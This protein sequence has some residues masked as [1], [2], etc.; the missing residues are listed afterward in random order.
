MRIGTV[1]AP[2]RVPHVVFDM[3]GGGRAGCG[4]PT[5]LRK[6]SLKSS[7]GC[8]VRN[9]VTTVQNSWSCSRA[10]QGVPRRQPGP[11]SAAAHLRIKQRVSRL[12]CDLA[13]LRASAQTQANTNLIVASV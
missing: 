1:V 6:L 9:R 11:A 12:H 5:V 4:G 10:V 8:A 2:A 13:M 7:R 3:V